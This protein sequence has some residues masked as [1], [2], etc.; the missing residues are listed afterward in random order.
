MGGVVPKWLPKND[1]VEFTYMSPTSSTASWGNPRSSIKASSHVWLM[2]P[3]AFRKFLYV[4]YMS[5]FVN[6]VSSRM[7]R[8]IWN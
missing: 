5:L 7:M 6:F 4:N 8:I 3:N 1:V 2:K